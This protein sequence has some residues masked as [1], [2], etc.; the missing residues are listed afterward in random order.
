M[1]FFFLVIVMTGSMTFIA[2]GQSVVNKDP[3]E[4]LRKQTHDTSDV[5]FLT[6]ASFNVS[7]VN[8][9]SGKVLAQKALAIARALHYK[10]G[11]SD[12]LNASGEAHHFLGEYP[13]ALQFFFQSAQIS[14]DV[15]DSATEA[16]TLGLIGMVY[17]E[18]G[19]YRQA[20]Q[21]LMAAFTI[22]QQMHSKYQG[23][24]ELSNIGDSYFFLNMPDS[25]VYYQRKAYEAY[26]SYPTGVHLKSF[27]LHHMG[28]AYALSG[29]N[30]S[31][32]KFY[33][34]AIRYSLSMNDKMNMSMTQHKI[35]EVYEAAHQYD[36]AVL[37]AKR[38]FESAKSVGSKLRELM[39]SS[40]LSKVYQEMKNADS[41]LYYL[42]IS[43]AIRDSLYGPE[44]I[45]QMQVLMLDEQQKQTIL[46][47]QQEE[48][49]TRI[50]Y[51]AL[52]SGAAAFLLLAFLLWRNNRHKKRSNDLLQKEKQ[53]VEQAY[54]ELKSA[55]A[56]LVQKEKMAS[57]GELTAGIAHEIQNPLN[58]VNNFS[59]V[60]TELIDEANQEINKGNMEEV[61]TILNNIKENEEKINH[62]G[63]RADA[64]VKNMLQHSRA[65]SGKKEVT[66]INALCDEYLR[67]SYHGLRAKDKSF[68]A[69]FET[70]FDESIGKI[71][72]IPQDIGRVLVNLINNAFYAAS[73]PSKGGLSNSDSNKIPAVWVSTKKDGNKILIS[74]RDNGPGIPESIKE[75]IFQP[76][77]TT[78]P[79][80]QGTG[81]GLSLSYDIVKA[82]GGE[83]KVESK[84]GEGSEFIIQLPVV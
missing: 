29:K 15:K 68:N 30:D 35:A 69:K 58:F 44:K 70:N 47:R 31:A 53:N 72:I 2:E 40:L 82:H 43:V 79:T 25:S 50:R 84:E 75:K 33:N 4:I 3:G 41:A 56:Q 59:D 10:K 14:R 77:F 16:E 32:L 73:Q 5:N 63:K 1:K 80:G 7:F 8:P 52:I 34:D 22:Y 37:Y 67:L 81:L 23:S 27:I 65:S 71:N 54:E 78:K 42:N 26:M 46:E 9:D 13:Q 11:E 12:A 28:N 48:Y 74:V 45:R 17:N 19:Q 83:I 62:H 60:N 20:I 55:Q 61:K 76:F 66:D 49:R 39:A 21:S 24:F 18:L 36:S 57:L 64:I 38:A 51:T 6:N